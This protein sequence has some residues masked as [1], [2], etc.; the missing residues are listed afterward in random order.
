MTID[1]ARLDYI[2][3][4]QRAGYRPSERL[5]QNILRSGDAAVGPLIELATSTDQLFLES[6]ERFAPVHALRLLGELR[7]LQMIEPLLRSF[8]MYGDDEQLARR[9]WETEVPQ[10]L[11]RL[12]APAAE[13]LWA[14]V[15]DAGY[16]PDQRAIA[17][18]ALAYATAVEPELRA[19]V[20]AGLRE[21][22]AASEDKTFT[23]HLIAG[24]ANLGAG[25]AY[26]EVMALFRAGEVDL[27]IATAAQARQ[28][29]LT[30]SPKRLGCVKHPLWERYD[31]HGPTP[32]QEL[33]AQ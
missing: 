17:I 30:Q 24:L 9:M 26:Q 25:E 5:A 2:H 28:F 31:E 1:L 13:P 12:G 21:R 22:L 4:L 32:D 18:M 10:I 11:G 16:T 8:A 14:I 19:P 33:A 20:I 23:G 6:P 29:L 7:P 15:D 3:Q 27:E